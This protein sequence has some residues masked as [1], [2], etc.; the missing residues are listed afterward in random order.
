MSTKRLKDFPGAA[1]ITGTDL[2]YMSQNGIEVAATPSQFAAS[3]SQNAAREIF[4]AGTNFTAGTTTSLTLGGTYGSINNII[5]LCDA[6]IQTDCSL[7]GQT[8]TFNPTIPL[9][10]QQVVVI[11]WPSR[12]I[13]VPA[14]SS[15]GDSQLAWT[16]I[17]NRV[18]DSIAGLRALSKLIYSRA[19]VT[20][21]YGVGDGGGG[22]Y[23]LNP[24]DTTSADNGGSIIV[25]ADGGRWYLQHNGTV[26]VK[27]FGCKGIGNSFNDTASFQAAVSTGL[28]IHVPASALGYYLTNSITLTQAGQ[29]IFGDGSV[30]TTIFADSGF[31]L[32]AQGIFVFNAPATE[33]NGQPG[34][35]PGSI[36]AIV[37]RDLKVTCIQPDTA[38][39]ASL[40][41]YPPQIY[42]QN[43]PR[44]Q[45]VNVALTLGQVAVDMRGNS[46]GVIF[47]RC[48]ISAFG[49]NVLIDGALDSV[50]FQTC[51]FWPF[52]MTANQL[53]I[54]NTLGT[55]GI[56]V[57]R[58]DDL[59]ISDGLMFPYQ[60]IVSVTGSSGPCF[61]EIVGVDFDTNCNV[62]LSA[63][64]G[65][66][67]FSCCYFTS[68]GGGRQWLVITNGQR[69]SF[70]N[71][72]FAVGAT[73]TTTLIQVAGSPGGYAKF[74]NCHFQ[75]GASDQIVCAVSGV[76]TGSNTP[77]AM[78][79]GCRFSRS[80]GTFT[81][82]L[83]TQGTSGRIHMTGSRFD[84]WSG[85][86]NN[87]LNLLN[88]DWH[89]IVG[90]YF[91]GAQVA[92]PA[93]RSQTLFAQNSAVLTAVVPQGQVSATTTSGG[94]V[95][96]NHNFGIIPAEVFINVVNSGAAIF[97]QASNFAGNTF[98]VNFFNAGGSPLASTAVIFDWR[99]EF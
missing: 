40:I 1:A 75:P 14:N 23:Y 62:A 19:F 26:S 82:P 52:D 93:T 28:R 92:L 24:A 9:G 3:I 15:V 30:N 45:L 88:D 95:I 49:N 69:A 48:S 96:V 79:S 32:S 84:D 63:L 71:C 18:T 68:N 76:G 72:S 73:D 50:K 2:I 29:V 61:G 7:S 47:D 12:S 16:G 89:V 13:G 44:F 60:G 17:L 8:L 78:F 85:T 36:P 56:W 86:S 90:N 57:G 5:V 97:A 67:R 27:Q 74:S 41:N 6:T 94:V 31:N 11:G 83:L 59:H 66:L 34:Y 70:D 51:H 58:C 37:M 80:N 43:Q 55:V 99:V 42:A 4:N 33:I 64:A 20:G 46:G 10:T 87:V 22:S 54:Y 39:R 77:T 98:Q 21:Y 65:D 25:A 38:T 81:T 53:S 35:G 91:G